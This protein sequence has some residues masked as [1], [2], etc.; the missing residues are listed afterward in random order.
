MLDRIADSLAEANGGDIRADPAR[1]RR[2][3]LAAMKPLEKPNE[4]MIDAAHKAVWSDAYWAIN[5]RRDFQKSVRA[6][7]RAAMKEG[8]G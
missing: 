5:S 1:Y 2:L 3:A 7:I 4:G 6:M 8:S